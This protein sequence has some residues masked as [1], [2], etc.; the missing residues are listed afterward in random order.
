M[1]IIYNNKIYN[2]IPLRGGM[3]S[4]AALKNLFSVKGQQ[5]F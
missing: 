5:L 3:H 1:I 2:H 4:D